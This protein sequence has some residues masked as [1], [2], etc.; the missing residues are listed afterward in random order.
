MIKVVI[1]HALPDANIEQQYL[2]QDAIVEFRH[3]PTEEA[4]IKNCKDA[5]AIISS[6]EPFTRNVISALTKCKIIAKESIGFDNIDVQAAAEKNIA[7]TNIPTY[8]I[9]EVADHTLALILCLNRNMILYNHSVQQ[10]EWKYDLCPGM[11]RLNGQVLGLVG[12]GNI[13]KQ[14]AK[15][16]QGFGLKIIAHDKFADISQ[17]ALMNVDMV[18]IDDLLARADLISTHLPLTKDT[19]AFFDKDKFNKM[20]KT[21]IFIN[22]SRGGLV[23]END[24]V[25]A[26]D[27]GKIKAAGVDVLSSEPPDLLHCK[28]LGR[29]NVIL[30]PH[31]AFYSDSSLY[32]MRKFSALSITH[33]LGGEIEKVNIVNGL[34]KK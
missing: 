19:A 25:D 30:T 12:F 31:M 34:K 20:K 14:V 7:V 11:I 3:S 15:R 22:T 24:L 23:V 9:N 4:L 13:A 33:Y 5:D 29:D 32:D 6:S 16:A 18:G 26:L 8:C 1:T 21:P 28:L 27:E 10:K 2:P 17:A